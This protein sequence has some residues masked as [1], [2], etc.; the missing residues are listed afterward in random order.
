MR[1][2]QHPVVPVPRAVL[3]LYGVSL[4]PGGRIERTGAMGDHDLLL[5]SSCRGQLTTS[6]GIP[7]VRSSAPSLLT[8]AKGAGL[9]I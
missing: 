2:L 8:S 1:T 9:P 3:G 4:P 5:P 7:R 6:A